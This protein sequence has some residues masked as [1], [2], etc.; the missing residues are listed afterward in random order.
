MKKV[1]WFAATAESLDQIRYSMSEK[2]KF[3][4]GEAVV[5][6]CTMIPA[7]Y[8][9]A[10]AVSTRAL[11]EEMTEMAA[12][13]AIKKAMLAAFPA[14]NWQVCRLFR[15]YGKPESSFDMIWSVFG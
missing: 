14:D 6:V 3:R 13:A 11:K 10:V 4:V 5:N 8:E 1:M 12:A 9:H 7:V 2:K 15:A